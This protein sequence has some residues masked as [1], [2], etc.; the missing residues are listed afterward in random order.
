MNKIK[1]VNKLG[2]AQ[3]VIK[4]LKGQQLNENEIYAINSNKVDG[5]LHLDVMQKGKTFKLIYNIT[6]FITLREYLATPLNKERFAKILQHI[7][8]NLKSMDQAYFNQQYLLMDFDKV[9][10]NP[11]TQKIYFI[12]VP[13]QFFES[14]NNLREFLLE[15]I[16]FASFL[17]GERTEYIKEYITILNNGVNFSVFDLEQYIHHL[18]GEELNSSEYKE[19]PQCHAKIRIESSYCDQCGAKLSGM[20]GTEPKNV[21]DPFEHVSEKSMP[22]EVNRHQEISKKSNTQGLSDGTTVLGAELGGTTVLGFEELDIPQFAYLIRVKS[23]EKIAV[24]KNCFR[25]GKDGRYCDYAV[26]DNNAVSRQHADIVTKSHRYFLIDLNST[27]KT[28][29]DGRV[30]P[31]EKEIEIFADADIRLANEDFKFIVE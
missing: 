4:S 25:I 26:S 13:I 3:I 6:G 1:S 28:Y 19:C 27:N 5:L 20:T 30:I 21:Y 18:L 14:R 23:G 16:Q 8:M 15:I 22:Y 2:V 7:L 12:Y 10:V 24:D 9:M 31:S 11:A 17:P 29:V